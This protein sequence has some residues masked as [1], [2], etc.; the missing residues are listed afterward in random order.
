MSAASIQ[1]RALLAEKFPGLATRLNETPAV[2]QPVWPVELSTLDADW[3]A[4][5]AKGALTEVVCAGI[6]FGSAGLIHALLICAAQE[7]QIVGVIDGSDSLDVTQFEQSVLSRL[8]WVRCRSVPEALKAAD[9][10]LRD[11]NFS[12]VMLDLKLNPESQL[13]KIPAATWY[14]LQRLI[15]KTSTV[16]VI[17]TPCLLVKA[18]RQRVILRGAS[19]V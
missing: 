11:S 4:G 3:P 16:F 10:M 17:F 13:R 7:N 2:S 5:L 15:E 19:F 18:I 14:R 8:F 12:L 1:L 6:N 9:L